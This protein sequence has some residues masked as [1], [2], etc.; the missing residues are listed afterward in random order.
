MGLILARPLMNWDGDD[1]LRAYC[2]LLK[3]MLIISNPRERLH[4]LFTSFIS[5]IRSLDIDTFCF[6]QRTWYVKKLWRRQK[7]EVYQLVRRK[8]CGRYLWKGESFWIPK[9]SIELSSSYMTLVCNIEIITLG[10]ELGAYHLISS[11]ATGGYHVTPDG[12]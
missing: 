11:G 12:D 7:R 6:Y 4:F 1:G 10:S 2:Q 3:D 8:N 9:N 5:L